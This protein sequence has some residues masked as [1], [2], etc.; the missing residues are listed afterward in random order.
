M[1]WALHELF[2]HKTP[3]VI[4]ISGKIFSQKDALASLSL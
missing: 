4:E 3:I 1:G 2:T